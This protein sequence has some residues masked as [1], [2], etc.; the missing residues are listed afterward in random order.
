[1]RAY[2]IRVLIKARP[3]RRS[4]T[5]CLTVPREIA[6]AVGDGVPLVPALT[7]AGLLYRPVSLPTPPAAL[8][9]WLEAGA[10]VQPAAPNA[11]TPGPASNEEETSCD[12][13]PLTP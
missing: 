9:S 12:R 13:N 2:K 3:G 10:A 11:E 1:M 4:D 7:E 8:P 5:Y 6:E